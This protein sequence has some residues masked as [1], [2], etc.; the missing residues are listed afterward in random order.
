VW[1]QWFELG[2]LQPTPLVLIQIHYPAENGSINVNT[3]TVEYCRLSLDYSV[4]D[5][6]II[7]WIE[8]DF[9]YGRGSV[10]LHRK[11]LD[12]QELGSVAINSGE[13]RM[14]NHTEVIKN[15]LQELLDRLLSRA[16]FRQAVIAVESGDGSFRWIGTKGETDSAGTQVR[17][18][19]PFFIASIDKLLN[20]TVAMKL[21]ESGQ[22]DLDATISTYL[23]SVLVRGL[24]RLGGVDYTDEITVRHLLAHT[25]GLPDWLEDHAPGSPSIFERVLDEGDMALTIEDM[26]NIV[27]DGHRPHFPPQEIS[28]PSPKVRYSDTNYMLLIAIIEAVA[29]KPLHQV[30]TELLF[31]PLDMRHT[32]FVGRSQP[33]DPTPKPVILR[34]KGDPLHIPL[35]LRS[36][37]GI[38]STSADTFTFL[39]HL[40]R[41]ELF[42]DPG[43]LALMQTRWNRFGFPLDRAALRAPSWPI[44]YGLGIMRF[45]LPR[46]VAPIHPMPAVLGHTGSTGCW[47]FYCP[48]WN[49]FL[50]GSVDEVTAGSLP[51]RIVPKLLRILRPFD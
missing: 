21:S 48:Q 18:G 1:D 12:Q 33:L 32:Y 17:E 34:A 45:R 47:L 10:P 42:E 3:V 49:M 39:R 16:E 11:N 8:S 22:L 31:R 15:Q 7:S 43:T 37:W 5:S 4:T 14:D 40:V 2:C 35:L 13:S 26:A 27:R 29:G 51:Y 9:E 25:S 28:S 38:Y 46:I 19:T 36:V 30:H 41:N 20:A 6:V 23:P 50:S 24:H 44:E